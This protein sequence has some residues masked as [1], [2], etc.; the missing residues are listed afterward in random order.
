MFVYCEIKLA[1]DNNTVIEV[2]V[3][4]ESFTKHK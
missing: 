2:T 3:L 1:E 4:C